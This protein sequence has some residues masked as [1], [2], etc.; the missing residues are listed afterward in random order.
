MNANIS[1]KEINDN[2]STDCLIDG[3]KSDRQT[4]QSIHHQS[5]GNKQLAPRSRG[6]LDV[7]QSEGPRFTFLM[8]DF[9]LLVNIKKCHM[10]FALTIPK[11]VDLFVVTLRVFIC[12]T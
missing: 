3:F 8:L 12:S 10:Y 6:R 5:R 4:L 9:P 7:S 2:L 11:S 1:C